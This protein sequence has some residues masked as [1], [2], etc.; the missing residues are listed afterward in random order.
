MTQNGRLYLNGLL[1]AP[2]QAPASS[3]TSAESADFCFLAAGNMFYIKLI[4]IA[5][6]CSSD[7]RKF[8]NSKGMLYPRDSESR[9][10]QTLDG[11][12]NFRADFSSSRQEGFSKKWFDLLAFLPKN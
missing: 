12:W 5:L 10:S 8:A 6:I 7:A 1:G 11:M 4:V 2:A 3:A 9:E